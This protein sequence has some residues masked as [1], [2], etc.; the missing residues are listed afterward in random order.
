MPTSAN[1]LY[2][3]M[4]EAQDPGQVPGLM[5]FFRTGPGEYGE[6]DRFLGIKVPVTRK[7]VRGCWKETG[8]VEL[9]EC[10]SS[11]FHEMRLAAL[12]A[13]VQKFARAGSDLELRRRCVDFYLS[14]LRYVN[15]WD[16]VDLSCY[17]LL[18][19][20]L[21]DKDRTLLYELARS[22]RTIWEKRIGMVSTMKFVRNGELDDCFAIAGIFLDSPEPLHDLLQKAAGW[23]LREAGKRDERRLRDWLGPRCAKMPRTM[24][25]YAIERM[26][27]PSRRH[28]MAVR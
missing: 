5:R 2:S 26:D 12:L 9:E 3:S 16:L 7:I 11:E 8:F 22:G 18:G 27:E 20:W 24:L 4:L 6:G 15:N 19:A 13:L 21:L 25:R 14:H 28:F 23:L 10:I 1:I 17:E